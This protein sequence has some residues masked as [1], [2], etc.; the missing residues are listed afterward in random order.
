ME[1][2]YIIS[3]WAG[4]TLMAH[5]PQQSREVAFARL[6]I[7]QQMYEQFDNRIDSVFVDSKFKIVVFDPQEGPVWVYQQFA[8]DEGAN[9]GAG[10]F[11]FVGGP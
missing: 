7:N 10:G 2:V 8:W 1:W 6:E 3:V 5:S 4:M 9:E 11:K